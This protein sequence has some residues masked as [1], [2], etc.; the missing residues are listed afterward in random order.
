MENGEVTKAK[1]ERRTYKI[2][3]EVSRMM[4]YPDVREGLHGRTKAHL[5]FE[6][7]K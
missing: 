6:V 7:L 3:T 4:N 2:V 5:K 1:G